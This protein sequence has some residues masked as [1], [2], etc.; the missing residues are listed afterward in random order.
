MWA[1]AGE[2]PISWWWASRGAEHCVRLSLTLKQ[3]LHLLVILQNDAVDLVL[4]KKA[5][6]G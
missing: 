5:L 4:F 1:M 2:Q 3:R 6:C